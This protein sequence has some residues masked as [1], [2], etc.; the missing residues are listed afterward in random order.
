M[1]AASLLFIATFIIST[2]RLAHAQSLT[3]IGAGNPTPGT[4]DIFQL[5]TNGNQALTGAFSYLTDNMNSPGQTFTTGINPLVITSLSIRTGSAPLSSGNGG[6]G[7]Q[8]YQLRLFSVVSNSATLLGT[9]TSATN[10]SY[11]DGDWL[12]WS[13]LFVGL[14]SNATY[15][16][17]FQRTSNGFGGLAVSSGNF[18]GGGEIVLIPTVG[19]SVTYQSSRALDATFNIGLARVQT[20]VLTTNAFILEAEKGLL[21]GN[22]VPYVTTSTA[23]YSGTGYVS[24]IQDATALVNFSF[25]VT[26]GL[27]RL[28]IRFRSPFGQKGFNGTINGHGFSGTF[29]Q[30]SSFA[31]FDAGLVQVVSGANTLQVGG[32]WN[33]YDIDRAVLAPATAPAP[34]LPVPATLADTN[35]TFAARMLM[36]SLVADYGK[37]TWAGQHQASEIPLIQSTSGRKPVI[38]SGDLMRYSPSRIQYG[39]N[40]GTYMEDQIALETNGHVMS[41][42]WHWNAPTNLLNTAAAPWGAGFNTYAT[43]FDISNVLA[44]TN[45]S[46]YAMMLRDIDAIAVQL[47][48]ASDKNIP[49]LWRPLHE[50]SGGWFWWGAKGP[51]PFKALWRLMFTRLTVHNNL[52]NLI[53]VLTNLDPDWYPGNDVVDIVGTDRYP[54]DLSDP[55]QSDWQAL[56]TQFNGVKLVTLTEIGGIPDVERMHLFGVWFAYF[57]PWNG[58]YIESAQYAPPATMTRIYNSPEVISLDEMN[59]RPPL[60]ISNMPIL[61]GSIQLAGTGRRGATYRILASSDFSIPRMNWPAITSNIFSGGVFTFKDSQAVNYSKRFYQIATP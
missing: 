17:T 36:K 21:M 47:K 16:Y 61:G 54:T 25:T 14:S 42:C 1:K 5:S 18:Y 26:P 48:K 31:D 33:Y 41:L 20:N 28:T 55:L 44:N 24:G 56:I 30:S 59:V 12:R 46:E 2:L 7:P 11:V 58:K 39:D 3:D 8:S 10:F 51:G 4:N 22:P 40:P 29:P 9:Y 13:N 53:W 43:T 19:G 37:F 38:V 49:I 60:I 45:S 32:G 15:A 34:P 35:A 6:L 57:V 23:G 50:A 27:Y 52:H